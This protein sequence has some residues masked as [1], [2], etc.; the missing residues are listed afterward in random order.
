MGNDIEGEAAN[1][2]F[3]NCGL[4]VIGQGSLLEGGLWLCGL[5]GV[6]IGEGV[7]L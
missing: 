6:E 3:Q 5:D 2:R 7:Q 1:L 4:Q